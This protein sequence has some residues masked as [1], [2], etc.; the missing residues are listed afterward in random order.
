[1]KFLAVDVDSVF[2]R[3]W[4][5]LGDGAV[6]DAARS[7]FSQIM[8]ARDD[9]DRIVLCGDKGRS[10]RI[11]ADPEY[12]AGRV[13]PG[14]A[15]REQRR[16]LVVELIRGTGA[17]AWASPAV[18]ADDDG[19][20]LYGEADD[21]IASFCLWYEEHRTAGEPGF[22]GV[23][24][25]SGD[26]D[27]WALVDDSLGIAVR[28]LEGLD[29]GTD[30]VVERFGVAPYLVPE[31]KAL[32]G[33]ASDRYA[34]FRHPERNGKGGSMPGI[35][36]K[37]AAQ[38][39]L[40]PRAD[41]ERSGAD[42]AVRRALDGE[43][44]LPGV[45][46]PVNVT[47]C[48]RHGGTQALVRGRMCA[49]LRPCLRFADGAWHPLDFSPVL[50]EPRP[51]APQ[52]PPPAADAPQPLT[53]TPSPPPPDPVASPAATT[54][55]IPDG[56]QRARSLARS[57]LDP[58]ALEPTGLES[59]MGLAHEVF[60]SRL[61]PNMPNEAAVLT[62]MCRARCLGI[63]AALA[64]DYFDYVQGRL[65][66][67]AQ[68]LLAVVKSH[69]TCRKLEFDW[70]RCTDQQAVL[71]FQR[72]GERAGEYSFTV[73]LARRA[74]FL[75]GKHSA[76]WSKRPAV[77]LRWAAVRELCRAVWPDIVGGLY[78]RGEIEGGAED[79]E[80]ANG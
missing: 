30:Q 69:H 12:K 21:V 47:T 64:G 10:F 19:R 57:G 75:D 24:I 71:L 53:P 39:V 59:A 73:E 52:E 34:P 50:A 18:A 25:L 32:M 79:I 8:G 35:G 42:A 41:D 29:I 14:E 55:A 62:L 51:G 4:E 45:K 67:R 70:P 33:D 28:T 3:R 11:A 74:G 66:W 2:R 37:T 31:L 7:A 40:G 72:A 44:P 43:E 76:Q 77:M 78:T 56:S 5:A 60:K 22:D 68:G 61:Y 1:M 17:T 80:D 16:I 36:P 63:P 20:D 49:H 15:Y 27:L 26:T 58:Y 48:L 13:D 9:C 46:L 65:A 6:G 54:L 23:R 38:I